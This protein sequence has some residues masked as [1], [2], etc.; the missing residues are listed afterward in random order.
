MID[1]DLIQFIPNLVS[2]KIGTAYVALAQAATV[3][4]WDRFRSIIRFFSS[5]VKA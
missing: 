2:F 4:A 5:S 3:R 1:L